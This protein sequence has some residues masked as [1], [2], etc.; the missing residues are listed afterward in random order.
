MVLA[1]DVAELL[2]CLFGERQACTSKVLQHTNRNH[3]T[4]SSMSTH[5]RP[6]KRARTTA[7]SDGCY[8]EDPNGASTTPYRSRRQIFRKKKF[9]S[10]THVRL[11]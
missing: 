7:D 4:I 11:S 9:C 10:P 3:R 5:D 6:R 8:W 2:L 1:S